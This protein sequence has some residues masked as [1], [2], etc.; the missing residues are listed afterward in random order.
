MSVDA[1]DGEIDTKNEKILDNVVIPKSWYGLAFSADEKFLYASGGNDNWILKY[2]I[3]NRKLHLKDSIQLGKK[4]PVPISPSG[5]AIDDASQTLYVVTKENNS[6][7]L[8]NLRTKQIIQRDSLGAE[9]YACLLSPDKK[10]LYISLWGGRKVLIFGV[11]QRK[12]IAEISVGDHPN[13]LLLTRNGQYLFVAN[14]N[15][16]SVS[17]MDVKQ[18][19][20][21][22]VLNAALYPNAPAGSTSNG[23]ALSAD[24][25]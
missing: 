21:L 18:R 13:E 2:A 24:D 23:L 16:N 1:N 25:R 9:A 5:I 3:T 12:I 8:V 7:Y 6:L 20:V 19:K 10:E 15:E 22:E 14:A 17:V 11:A 4:W